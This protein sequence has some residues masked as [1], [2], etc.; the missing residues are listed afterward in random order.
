MSIATVSRALNSPE[1]VAEATRKRVLGVAAEMGYRPSTLGRNLVTGRSHLIGLMIPNLGTPLYGDMAMGIEDVFTG[2]GLQVV[3]A[4]TRDDPD[5]ELQAT[6]DLLRHS[7]DCGIVI[8][9]RAGDGSLLESHSHWVHISP[10]SP[11]FP[12]R[13]EL[14]NYAGGRLAVQH[15]VDLGHRRVA[16][17]AGSLREG[18]DRERG[19]RDELETNDLPADLLEAG[20]YT[21]EGGV[22]ATEALLK[23]E[24]PDAIFA[25][26]D[27]MAV[28]ALQAL[29]KAGLSVPKD[30]SLIGFDDAAYADLVAPRLS[31]VQQPSYQ[32]GRKAAELVLRHLAQEEPSIV[33]LHPRVIER[34]STAGRL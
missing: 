15:L 32:M 20:D 1:T 5:L 13:V 21:L 19:W 25:A 28:G 26:G 7:V 6:Q 4:S 29:R 22:R 16:H 17:V 2:T 23:R 12:L 34:E 24:V 3:L 8:N 33:L 18:K 9:S 14:D 31:T 10:E 11:S 27:L 30:V